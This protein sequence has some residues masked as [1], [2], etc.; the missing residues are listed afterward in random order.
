VNPKRV[1]AALALA[2]AALLLV[3]VGARAVLR[4]PSNGPFFSSASLAAHSM[5]ISSRSFPNGGY[6]PKQ[7]TCDGADISPELS[8]TNPPPGAQSLALIAEDPDAPVGTWTHWVIFDLPPSTRSLPEGVGKTMD[9]LPDGGRQGANDFGKIGYGGPCPPAGKPHRYFFKL[10]AVD[11]KLD[12]KPS[13]TRARFDGAIKN[14]VLDE[15]DWMGRYR[16]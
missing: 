10:Y 2:G 4:R 16:R 3:A 13:S 7:F 12:L 5:A 11:R 15:A 8:W 9:Q 6:I 1:W 14:H